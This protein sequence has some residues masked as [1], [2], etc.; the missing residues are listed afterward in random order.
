MIIT[1]LLQIGMCDDGMCVE[2]RGNQARAW[3]VKGEVL[4]HK[5]RLFP[6]RYAPFPHCFMPIKHQL[7]CGLQRISAVGMKAGVTALFRDSRRAR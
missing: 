5:G 1:L 4:N 6:G 2:L 7:C 3:R